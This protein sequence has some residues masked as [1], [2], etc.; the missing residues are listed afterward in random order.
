V[1]RR[2]ALIADAERHYVHSAL[3]ASQLDEVPRFSS[4][5]AD[6]V[7]GGCRAPMPGKILAVRVAAGDAVTKGQV[8]VILEAM[9]ME[10]EVTAPDDGTVESIAVEVGQ[11]VEAGAVLV[12]LS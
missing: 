4:G 3:G 10:H 9:K 6:D 8:L 2:Y 5:Q 11:Q 7:G 12:V 1:R